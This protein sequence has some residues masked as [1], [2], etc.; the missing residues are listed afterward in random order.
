MNM[1]S[2][3]LRKM[4]IPIR[5]NFEAQ[6]FRLRYHKVEGRPKNKIEIPTTKPEKI[7]EA[8]VIGVLM[9]DGY[10]TKNLIRLK[11]TQKDFM[12]EFAKHVKTAY[13][14]PPHIKEYEEKNIFVCTVYSVLLSK[15]IIELTKNR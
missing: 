14:I 15:R 1:K 12:W 10:L 7:S 4:N 8:Y 5:N 3:K 11:V 6:K 2:I 9:G 13:K